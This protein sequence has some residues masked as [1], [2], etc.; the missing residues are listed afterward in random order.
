MRK[1]ALSGA[2]SNYGE[3]F[4]VLK[5]LALDLAWSW[6]HSVH[7]LWKQLDPELW[8]RT[9]NPLLMLETVSREQLL[10]IASTRE[11]KEC[12]R[13]VLVQRQTEDLLHPRIDGSSRA[14]GPIAYFSMEYM[15]TEAL[16]IYSGGLGNVAGDQL[17]AA[18]DLDL[19]VTG[20]GLLFQQGYFRQQIEANGEQVAFYPFNN[21]AELPITPVRREDGEWVRVKITR[22]DFTLWLRAWQAKVG[23]VTLYLL[24]T[25]DPANGPV[26]RLVGSELYGGGPQLRLRQEVILG[27]GGWRLLRELGIE[28]MVCHLNEGHAAFAV[29]ERARCFMEDNSTDFVTALV[30]TRAGNVF[31]THTP[32]DAGFDRFA[33]ELMEWHLRF[34]SEELLHIPFREFLALGRKNPDDGNEPF[35]MAYLAMR[36]SAAVNGVSR[37]H[38]EVSRR[39]F[40]D[41]FPR[42]PEAEVPV[43]HVTNGIHVPTW[44]SA[45]AVALWNQGLELGKQ[46]IRPVSLSGC[47]REDALARL[48]DRQLWDLRHKQR[49]KLVAFARRRLAAQR[50]MIGASLPEDRLSSTLDPEIL[51]LGFARR[52]AE[53]KRPALL[54]RDPERF[55]RILTD[56]ARPAQLVLAGKAHPADG[57]GKSAIKQ[58]HDYIQKYGLQDRIV[59]LADY[60]MQLTQMLVRGADLW[61][62]TPRRPWEASGTSGMKILVNGGLNLSELDGW[63]VEA[64]SPEVGWGI[65]ATGNGGD[66][67]ARDAEQLYRLLEQE[68]KP[69]FYERDSSGI[70]TAWVARMRA[71]MTT[72]TP[73]FSAYRTVGEY[74]EQYYKPAALGYGRR[75][76]DGGLVAKQ[77]AEWLRRTEDAWSSVA[78][79]SRH[80]VLHDGLGPDSLWEITAQVH[81]GALTPN[82]VL[83]ELFADNHGAAPFRQRMSL[84]TSIGDSNSTYT[85]KERASAA[86]SASDYTV[87]VVLCHTE[88]QVPLEANRILWEK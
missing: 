79:L 30:A 63:W 36:G 23:A 45:E 67:D 65:D 6:N 78:I 71:S 12:L 27:I 76:A 19:P 26:V 38:G 25:N 84:D 7:L 20:I 48:T 22:P 87:R 64:Y 29:V 42:W 10:R 60:D 15:L 54:L 62:N 43:G 44:A 80:S 66:E 11:F 47:I 53:Y 75:A 72:L 24:D 86:R 52:F 4:A 31:T 81:L 18:S 40:Q 56:P 37:I 13:N 49:T 88:V 21:P 73:M 5:D 39:I 9:R 3:V 16:P 74:L 82:D 41:L 77:L 50:A 61:I 55:A 35:N 59:F 83:V 70:P 14:I 8:D 17:K 34:Y 69:A 46:D 32:V 28:P 85:F 68:V 1:R 51:T 2:T 58:W 33:P 57:Y